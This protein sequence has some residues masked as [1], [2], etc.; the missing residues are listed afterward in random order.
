[1]STYVLSTSAKEDLVEIVRFS[2]SR[3]GLRA[4]LRLIEAI[5]K[6]LERLGERPSIGRRFRSSKSMTLRSW[7]VFD[8]R[9]VYDTETAP[10]R[11]VCI[12]H[13]ARDPAGIEDRIRGWPGV[14]A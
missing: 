4:A 13:G 1:M 10:I 8:Y 12:V 9:I 6:D 3:G 2:E 11:I 14:D 7:F 5:S